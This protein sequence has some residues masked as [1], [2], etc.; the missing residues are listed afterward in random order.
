M[1]NGI[2]AHDRVT[3][4][5]ARTETPL[6]PLAIEKADQGFL[7]HYKNKGR[8]WSLNFEGAAARALELFVAGRSV[9]TDPSER[10]VLLELRKFGLLSLGTHGDI[11]EPVTLSQ[12]GEEVKRAM[13][14][15]EDARPG[16]TLALNGEYSHSTEARSLEQQGQQALEYP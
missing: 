7:F 4:G 9:P 12:L 13:I 10:L 5:A 16:M 15:M 3:C 8:D 1:N 11:I 6:A 14:Q 2:E